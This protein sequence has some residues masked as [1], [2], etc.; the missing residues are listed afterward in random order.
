MKQISSVPENACS[1]VLSICASY[2]NKQEAME[3][4]HRL[5][6]EGI[7]LR[8]RHVVP[9]LQLAQKTND[10][11]LIDVVNQLVS[12][13]PL[14]L[15]QKARKES[16]L[17][18]GGK[19]DEQGVINTLRDLMKTDHVVLDSSVISSLQQFC[20]LNT[21]W[22]LNE[23]RISRNHCSCCHHLLTKQV[24]T[25]QERQKLCKSIEGMVDTSY[26]RVQ[27]FLKFQEDLKSIE[28]FDVV[29]DG[30]N[31][32]FMNANV[33][34]KTG[35]PVTLST[36][37]IQLITDALRERE[38]K[39]LVVL[40]HYHLHHLQKQKD[41]GLRILENLQKE[42]QLYLVREGSNDDW[43]WLY[44]AL[45]SP[46]RMFVTNDQMRDHLFNAEEDENLFR[47]FRD[48]RQIKYK[49]PPVANAASEISFR[50]PLRYSTCIQETTNGFHLP[51]GKME[52]A[53]FKLQKWYCLRNRSVSI[54]QIMRKIH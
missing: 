36:K 5:Q 25:E 27:Q 39:P 12:S 34:L 51:F 48:E 20:V 2:G 24:L 13:S 50:F 10:S 16:I 53:S 7:P 29:V 9:L 49:I 22:E 54:A 26:R 28:P 8:N 38:M 3:W 43:Y 42:K 31:I 32:G 21:S 1:C 23:M 18:Y 46:T 17:Y 41:P 30:A 45:M 14:D 33:R 52:K 40:H 15:N 19:G 47:I 35:F 4:V 6:H 11:E 44:A 37:N